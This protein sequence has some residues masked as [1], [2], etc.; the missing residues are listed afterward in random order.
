MHVQV[1]ETRANPATGCID[2]E[3]F[4]RGRV[5]CASVASNGF[6]AAGFDYDV[7]YFVEPLRWVENAAAP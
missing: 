6:D 3:S 1:D 2:D 5:A 4:V 7:G